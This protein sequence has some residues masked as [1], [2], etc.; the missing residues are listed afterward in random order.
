MLED[1]LRD[2]VKQ[3]MVE[4]RLDYGDLA[5]LAVYMPYKGAVVKRTTMSFMGSLEIIPS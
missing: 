5:K 4:E 3:R 2:I 1:K